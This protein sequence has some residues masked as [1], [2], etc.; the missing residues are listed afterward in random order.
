MVKHHIEEEETELLVELKKAV[1]DEDLQQLGEAYK[2]SYRKLSL[3][4]TKA[5]TRIKP[6]SSSELSL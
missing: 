1:S 5:H 3:E 2:Q 4:M 6:E